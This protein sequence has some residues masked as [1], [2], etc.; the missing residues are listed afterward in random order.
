MN[1]KPAGGKSETSEIRGGRPVHLSALH[2]IVDLFTH[3]L[4]HPGRLFHKPAGLA[5]PADDHA[6][7]AGHHNPG[8]NPHC[9]HS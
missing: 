1:K 5:L 8:Q 6:D 2:L 7:C 4:D 9:L 3:I